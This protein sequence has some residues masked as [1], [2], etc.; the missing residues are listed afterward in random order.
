VVLW[1]A[2]LTVSCQ[3]GVHLALAPLRAAQAPKRAHGASQ[4]RPR[5]AVWRAQISTSLLPATYKNAQWLAL[6][7]PGATGAFVRCCV[8]VASSIERAALPS[9]RHMVVLAVVL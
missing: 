7:V 9:Q 1:L 6:Q 4:R 3:P 2:L 8:T 5:M